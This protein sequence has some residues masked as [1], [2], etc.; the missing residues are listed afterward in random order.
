MFT[1]SGKAVFLI[2]ANYPE[3]ETRY[4]FLDGSEEGIPRASFY[5]AC[6]SGVDRKN[7]KLLPSFENRCYE[8]RN[9]I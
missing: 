4:N 3:N 7:L 8:R 2:M 1:T 5:N 9:V 6:G